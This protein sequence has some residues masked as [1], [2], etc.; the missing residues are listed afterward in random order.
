MRIKNRLGRQLSQ[1]DSDFILGLYLL[2]CLTVEM[3]Q[4]EASLL[5]LTIDIAAERLNVGGSALQEA[6]LAMRDSSHAVN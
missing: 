2:T 1:D 6:E 4:P 5:K 3:G